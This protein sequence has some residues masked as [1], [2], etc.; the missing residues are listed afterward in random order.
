MPHS[1]P[2]PPCHLLRSLCGV[3]ASESVRCDSEGV[4]RRGR[5]EGKPRPGSSEEGKEERQR[6]EGG[7]EGR[8]GV[9]EPR[10]GMGGGLSLLWLPLRGMT[11]R[12]SGIPGRPQGHIV[13]LRSPP[14]GPLAGEGHVQVAVEPLL[15]ACQSPARAISGMW[16]LGQEGGGR[17]AVL[18]GELGNCQQGVVGG[19]PRAL[20]LPLWSSGFC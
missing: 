18:A 5:E 9:G 10:E 19:Q 20:A 8:G 3:L 6:V 16:K 2:P 15:T 1:S 11:G 13:A 14:R 7:T 12:G 17:M 4:G